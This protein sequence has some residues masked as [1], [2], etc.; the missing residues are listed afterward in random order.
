[1]I[2]GMAQSLLNR[3]N[4]A[5][6]ALS[7]RIIDR[8]THPTGVGYEGLENT[9]TDLTPATNTPTNTATNTITATITATDDI[10]YV[11]HARALTDVIVLDLIAAERGLPS[12]I[13][14]LPTPPDG[15]QQRRFFCLNRTRGL[16]LGR[17]GKKIAPPGLL[18][19]QALCTNQ[20]ELNVRLV[21]V[22]VIWGRI[23]NRER[24]ILRL[25][26]SDQWSVTSRL[27]RLVTLVFNRRDILV[28]FGEPLNFNEVLDPELPSDQVTRRSLRLLRRRF[29]NQRR[30]ALG[31]DLSHQR[32]LVEQI[33]A[34]RSVSQEIKRQANAEKDPHKARRRLQQ[35]AR[36]DARS[37]ASNMSYSVIQLFDR[38][39]RFLWTRMY[40]GVDL[41]GLENMREYA[42]QHTLVYVPCHRSHVDYLLLSYLLY[43]NGLTIP[44]IA[45][46]DNLNIPV[47]G[48]LLRRGGAFFMRRKFRN[49][50]IYSAVFSEYL[51]QVYRRGHSVEFFIEGGR[52]RTGRLLQPQTGLLN[53]T[54]DHHNRGIPKPVVFVPVYFGYERLIESTSY[55]NELRG[56]KK[57]G[58]SLGGIFRSLKLLKQSFGR[59]RVNMGRPLLL[60][61]F[62]TSVA[63]LPRREQAQRLGQTLAE[64]INESAHLTPMNLVSLVTLATPRV[65]IDERQLEQQLDSLTDLLRDAPPNAQYTLGDESGAAI[66]KHVEDLGSL[67]REHLPGGDILTHSPLHTVLMTWYRNN[68]LHLVALPAFIA[69]LVY[70]RAQPLP[71]ER[72]NEL[73]AQV[74]PYLRAELMLRDSQNTDTDHWL[75]TMETQGL[76]VRNAAGDVC[77]PPVNHPNYLRLQTLAEVILQNL[78]RLYIVIA[79]L[80]QADQ[81]SLRRADLE[82]RC[83]AL[84]QRMSRLHGL[85]APEFFDARLIRQFISELVRHDVVSQDENGLLSYSD[86]IPEVMIAATDVLPRNFRQAVQRG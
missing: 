63:D 17:S 9:T 84:A 71:R 54:I 67:D 33:V 64:L 47:V 4:N 77:A 13:S 57:Q 38:L 76:L 31:P 72:L 65:A 53:M 28:Q 32:T 52:T 37:I 61:D 75:T 40:E 60:G 8:L 79:L 83:Q 27:R 10:V 46:G 45:A 74:F 7:R 23:P 18:R 19:L 70:R 21:P 86:S 16:L 12:P 85:N 26:V 81:A 39:L 41:F 48:P 25:L 30:A 22:N 42:Q 69:C 6:Y 68:V 14:R 66:I 44:H 29:T 35:R 24:S 49:D 2:G 80:A 11:L 36:K 59:V 55:V 82:R 78:E 62:L 43:Q 3:F 1:M 51:Y 58:E 34:S 50:S 5:R 56:A 15:P 20:P 73:I